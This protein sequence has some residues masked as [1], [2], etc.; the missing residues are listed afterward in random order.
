MIKCMSN[1]MAT[2][3]LT[4][5]YNHRDE[6]T[7]E[8]MTKC[9]ESRDKIID[10]IFEEVDSHGGR[11]IYALMMLAMLDWKRKCVDELTEL[12]NVEGMDQF[13][14]VWSRVKERVR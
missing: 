8:Q 6:Y 11:S 13:N 7:E 5:M 14:E 3:K 1:S 12:T 9:W 10:W 4:D 2:I